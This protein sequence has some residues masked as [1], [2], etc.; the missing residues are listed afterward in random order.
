MT[1]V[2]ALL[3]AL[4][5][6]LSSPLISDERAEAEKTLGVV[7]ADG[8]Q[9]EDIPL[10]GLEEDSEELFISGY[11]LARV[12]KASRH[13]NPGAR[14]LIL[15]ISGH[16]FMFTLDTRVV[17]VDD[18]P[19]LMRVPVRYSEG[20]VMIP[21][22]F[23]SAILA[24]STIEEIDL[25]EETLILT[26]GSPEYNVTGIT[27]TD[28]EVWSKAVLDLTEELLYH[29]DSE[30]PGLLRVKIYGGRLNTLKFS[31]TAGKGLFNKT[32]AEQTEHDAYLFFDVKKTAARFRVEFFDDAE[33]GGS[34]RKLVIFLEKTKLPEIP[35]PDFA[36]MKM[37]EILDA[38]TIRGNRILKIAIDPGHGGVDKGKVSSSGIYEKDVNLDYSILL[39]ERLVEEF[40]VEVVMTRTDDILVP[41]SRRAEIANSEDADLFISIHCNGWFHQ[42]ASGFETFFL[43]PARSEDDLRLAREENASIQ[44]ENPELKPEELDEL[45]FILWDIVQ[46]EFISESSELAELIQKEMSNRLSIRNRGVKQAG[47]LVLRGLKM[48][49]VLVEIAFL[50]NPEEEILVQDPLFRARV[51]EGIVNAVRRFQ[52]KYTETVSMTR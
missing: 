32:R 14:K 52:E 25:D 13:W 37:T 45:D 38:E 34:A 7:Y 6:G 20:L 31:V 26:I 49:A 36:G 47:L 23:I 44:F 33:G 2:A 24:S 4:L 39:S 29:V 43:A 11:N 1:S 9:T 50:S 28:D 16:R 22:E 40:G 41:L 19:V 15:S 35:D 3:L 12:F 51:I 30:T 17:I 48:P 27:F 21:I 42:D 18:Q 5:S 8:R 10:L 46:N